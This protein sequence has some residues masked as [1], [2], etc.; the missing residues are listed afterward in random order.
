MYIKIH[1]L[2]PRSQHILKE[3]CDVNLTISADSA[4]VN[5]YQTGQALDLCSHYV[6]GLCSWTDL[7]V[8]RSH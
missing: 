7:C 5:F 8:A 3:R 4:T 2:A 1:I 6:M